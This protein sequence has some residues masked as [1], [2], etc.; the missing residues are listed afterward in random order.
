MVPAEHYLKSLASL[1]LTTLSTTF[2]S[3]STASLL[4]LSDM[5]KLSDHLLKLSDL[6]SKP[7]QNL[8]PNHQLSL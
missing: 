7:F 2:V 3:V 6:V 4:P 8:L 1:C 5:T